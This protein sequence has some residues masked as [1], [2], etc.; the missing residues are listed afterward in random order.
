MKQ[1]DFHQ[2]QRVPTRH[3]A[4]KTIRTKTII[5]QQWVTHGKRQRRLTCLPEHISQINGNHTMKFGGY[6]FER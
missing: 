4:Q 2:Q 5:L 3:F 6:D 1:H